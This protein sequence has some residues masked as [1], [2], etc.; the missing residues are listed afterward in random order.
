MSHRST[1]KP[2]WKRNN[3]LANSMEQN[4]WKDSNSLAGQVLPIS[5]NLKVHYRVH[6]SPPLVLSRAR[7]IQSTPSHSVS[8]RPILILFFHLH[9]GIPSDHF[10]VSS[11]K[12]F[13]HFSSLPYVPHS[14]PI[15]SSSIISVDWHLVSWTNHESLIVQFRHRMNIRF[16]SARSATCSI[17]IVICGPGALPSLLSNRYW[18]SFRGVK[19]PER[20]VN[21]LS[22][23]SAKF[24]NEWSYTPISP[25]RR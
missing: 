13:M 16:P 22:L 21:H 4:N 7:C 14:P 12:I 11:A 24:K 15:S 17:H 25:C 6:N 8:L 20:E 9:L 3:R 23:W 5:W 10:Q 18:G 1:T 19:W 2:C